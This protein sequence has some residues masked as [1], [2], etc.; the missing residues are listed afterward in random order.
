MSESVIY[1]PC[2]S[3]SYDATSAQPSG[4]RIVLEDQLLHN[5]EWRLV[6]ERLMKVELRG[7]SDFAWLQNIRAYFDPEADV[8]DSPQ[9]VLTST[10][11]QNVLADL[12]GGTGP[13]G[14][15]REREPETTRAD[16]WVEQMD[17]RSP[18]LYHQRPQPTPFWQN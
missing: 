17:F 9:S 18:Y 14:D 7:R 8:P 11:R 1:T 2:F 12:P 13:R 15:D 16:V 10:L 3:R 5:G 6:L 4:G